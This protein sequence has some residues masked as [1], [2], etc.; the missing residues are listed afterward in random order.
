MEIFIA[1]GVSHQNQNQN[2]CTLG[3]ICCESTFTI[4]LHGLVQAVEASFA[5]AGSM[6]VRVP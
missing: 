6:H 4:P 1:S 2:V 5:F 3:N